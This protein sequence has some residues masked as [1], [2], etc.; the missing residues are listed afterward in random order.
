MVLFGK[1]FSLI[2]MVENLFEGDS[3]RDDS[4][5]ETEAIVEVVDVDGEQEAPRRARKSAAREHLLH[6]HGKDAQSRLVCLKCYP[7]FSETHDETMW[8]R[9]GHQHRGVFSEPASEHTLAKHAAWHE[10]K[11]A[12]EDEHAK[13]STSRSAGASTQS[14]EANP[15]QK[16]AN[17]TKA[18]TENFDRVYEPR[19]DNN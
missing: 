9:A 6:H 11:Q 17:R 12:K 5:S 15:K 18:C 10:E 14:P 16:A 13:K 7:N 1:L 2:V 3:W 8:Q 4:G 19:K